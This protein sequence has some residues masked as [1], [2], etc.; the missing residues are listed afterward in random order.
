LAKIVDQPKFLVYFVYKRA[1]LLI[2]RIKQ[3]VCYFLQSWALR[4]NSWFQRII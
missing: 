1:A 4:L 3:L 2:E